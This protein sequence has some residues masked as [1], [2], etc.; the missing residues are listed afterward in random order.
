MQPCCWSRVQTYKSNKTICYQTLWQFNTWVKI[1]FTPYVFFFKVLC[2]CLH[3][4]YSPGLK[5]TS[6]LWA[7]SFRMTCLD[8]S[9]DF[10]FCE[11]DVNPSSG[12]YDKVFFFYWQDYLG[13]IPEHRMVH[14][15]LS[16]G[17][18]QGDPCVWDDQW[19]LLQVSLIFNLHLKLLFFCTIIFCLLIRA[20]VLLFQ[21]FHQKLALRSKKVLKVL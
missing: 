6:T 20:I 4:F 12:I 15:Y 3:C 9:G 8:S 13:V 17:H 16:H 2:Q 1:Y 10:Y 19:H 7:P 11:H 18:M 5:S 14:P 21:T